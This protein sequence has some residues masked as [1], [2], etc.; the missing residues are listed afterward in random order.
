MTWEFWL[1]I[2]VDAVFGIAIFAGRNW[3][4]ATIEHSVQH[5]FDKEIEELRTELRKSEETFKSELRLKETEIG[6]L[7]D[8][9]LSGRTQRQA[10]L[11]R[12]RLDAV[13]RLWA[14]DI[15]FYGDHQL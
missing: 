11:D 3:L 9:I 5:H 8:G 6:A 7:R 10:F 13:E 15:R 2:G 4:K 12:R 1:L 14:G